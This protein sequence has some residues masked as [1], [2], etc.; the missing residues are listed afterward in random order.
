M[1]MRRTSVR[2]GK[3]YTAISGRGKTARADYTPKGMQMRNEKSKSITFAG[4]GRPSA[5]GKRGARKYTGGGF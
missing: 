4:L 3:T 1:T 2:G 5:R